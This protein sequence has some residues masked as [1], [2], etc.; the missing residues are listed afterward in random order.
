MQK[1]Q[2][3]FFTIPFMGRKSEAQAWLQKGGKTILNMY[4]QD[5]EAMEESIWNLVAVRFGTFI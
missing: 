1:F 3:S 5:P 4:Y 2:W